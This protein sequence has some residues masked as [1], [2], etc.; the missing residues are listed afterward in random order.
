MD[1]I[2]VPEITLTHPVPTSLPGTIRGASIGAQ[3]SSAFRAETQ[4]PVFSSGTVT[5]TVTT[6]VTHINMKVTNKFGATKTENIKIDVTKRT[7]SRSRS[8]IL[9]ARNF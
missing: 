2:V 9:Y 7:G 4:F 3:K 8:K 6:E 5:V 1:L